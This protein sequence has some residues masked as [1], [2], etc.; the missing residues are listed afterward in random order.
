MLR[1]GYGCASAPWNMP[2]IAHIAHDAKSVVR[3]S[4]VASSVERLL[5]DLAVGICNPSP[6][7][8]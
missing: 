7:L 8:A 4:M 1:D 5:C 6:A 3:K 2:E